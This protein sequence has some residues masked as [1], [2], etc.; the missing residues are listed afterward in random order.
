MQLKDLISLVTEGCQL[1]SDGAKSAD[2]DAARKVGVA[3]L[4]YG[5]LMCN[6]TRNYIFDIDEFLQFD[7]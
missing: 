5:D 7:E 2:K 4:K 1:L 6:R 3:A